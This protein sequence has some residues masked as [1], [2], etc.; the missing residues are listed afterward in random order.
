MI[1]L[2]GDPEQLQQLDGLLTAQSV[3]HSQVHS[4]GQAMRLLRSDEPI[5]AML[6]FPGFK[7]TAWTELCRTIKF[8]RRTALTPIIFVLPAGHIDCNASYFA[9]GAD[10]C[11]NTLAPWPEIRARISRQVNLKQPLA[12]ADDAGNVIAALANA[13]EG[14][15]AYTCGHVERVAAYALEVGRRMGVDPAGLTALRVGGL[16]HDI[17][18]VGIP[19]A[20]LN[21]PGRL[22]DEEM[23]I[24]QRHPVIGY[25]ILKSLRTFTDVLPIV[26]WHHERPNGTG[27]PDGIMGDRL[28]LLPRIVAVVDTFDAVS[29]SRPYRTA[30][31]REK[32]EAILRE[33]A[34]AGRLDPDAT[35]CLL[36]ILQS[37]NLPLPIAHTAA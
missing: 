5:D 12:F 3:T 26:R 2:A 22:T 27:Y 25:D 20:I 18:K 4:P 28:P 35:A 32:C 21:K 10:D 30:L 29:T 15:D 16:V 19:D 6:V 31:P 13:I 9:A 24:M 11:I 1:V 8:D 36:E 17:G 14:K 34:A 23:H 7:G 33:D 37:S